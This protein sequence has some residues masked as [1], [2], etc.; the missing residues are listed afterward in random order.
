MGKA[1]R[2][3]PSQ[4]PDLYSL[5]ERLRIIGRIMDQ[6]QA[7]LMNIR[8]DVNDLTF[9]YRDQQGEVHREVYSA[10]A[11]HKL[12]EQYYSER[13]LGRRIHG[14]ERGRV[15]DPTSRGLSREKLKK[16]DYD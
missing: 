4:S 13:S 1:C 2:S 15:D 16:R 8:L 9:E 10:K 6:K 3:D 5:E 12:Q 7:S 14:S 11:F